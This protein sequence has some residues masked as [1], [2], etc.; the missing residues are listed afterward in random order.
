MNFSFNGIKKDYIEIAQGEARPFFAP[1]EHEL[2]QVPGMPGAYPSFQKMGIRTISIPINIYYQTSAELQKIKEEMA[3]WLI[4]DEPK[5][6]IFDDEPDRVYYAK[7]DNTISD[8]EEMIRFGR[9]T[10]TF[11]C[12]DPYKY[13]SELVAEFPSDVVLLRNNGTA[14]TPPIFELEVK[15]P[16]TYAMIQNQDDEYMMIGKPYD[17][18][19]QQ[20]FLKEEKIYDKIGDSTTGWATASTVDGGVVD[21]IFYVSGQAW[22]AQTYGDVVPAWHGPSIQQSLP[23]LLDDFKVEVFMTVKPKTLKSFGRAELYLLNQGGAKIGKLAMKNIGSEGGSN[24][25]EVIIRNESTGNQQTLIHTPGAQQR[26]WN[27]FYGVL[28]LEREN[29]VFKAYIAMIDT[30]TGRHHTRWH[31]DPFVDNQGLY[32]DL[33]AGVQLHIGQYGAAQFI[34]DIAIHRII[35]YKINQPGDNQIQ[36]IAGVGDKITFDHK[37]KDILINGESRKDLKNF[38]ASYFKLKPGE[39]QLVV[40]P[41]NAV[42]VTCRYRERFK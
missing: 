22:R 6:L 3:D 25:G 36:Y 10:I 13:G 7:I 19:E 2:I 28:R 41:E 12:P 9:G 5:E 21:G 20:P 34:E 18:T 26:L 39:N 23:E 37:D 14:D 8:L 29:G 16:V 31:S 4:T 11:I 24:I 33:L 27:N 15:E 42:D 40:M 32:D 38:G 35:I 1:I 30:E 17:I